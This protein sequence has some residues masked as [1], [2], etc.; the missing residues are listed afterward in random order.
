MR[1][2]RRSEGAKSFLVLFF[3]K[4]PLAL[5]PEQAVEERIWQMDSQAVPH[6]PRANPRS[7][8][9]S[10]QADMIAYLENPSLD[11]QTT[12]FAPYTPCAALMMVK[13]EADIIRANLDWLYAIGVRRFVVTDND[14]HDGTWDE[15]TRFRHERRDVEVLL[16]S[17]PIVAHYQ[18]RKTSGMCQLARSV[19]PDVEWLFPVDADEFLNTR[20][21][22]RS[23]VY[24]PDEVSVLT[25]PKVIHFQTRAGH[26]LQT[27]PFSHMPVRCR[28]FAVP[29]KIILRASR[30]LDVSLGNHHAVSASGQDIH[31]AGGLQYGFFHREFQTRSFAQFRSKVLNGGPAVLAAMRMGHDV[32]GQHWLAWYDAFVQ[33]GEAALRAEYETAAFREVGGEYVEDLFVGK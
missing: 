13:D 14:S 31:H 15:L 10:V 22:L 21:G 2:R 9:G 17:D 5:T 8:A 16:I 23:L 25:V 4:E 24:V 26:T 33:G 27:T 28:P 29:P 18:A 30:W 3:K 20:F 7:W 11:L 19:W 1:V 32:G 12:Q 6:L